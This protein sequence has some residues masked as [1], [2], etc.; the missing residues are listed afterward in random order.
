MVLLAL[1][2][3]S[4]FQGALLCFP[5]FY[6]SKENILHCPQKTHGNDYDQTQHGCEFHAAYF[7]V[8]G[9]CMLEEINNF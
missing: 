1:I 2:S 4:A 5:L 9:S 8:S 3:H 7:R 6:E